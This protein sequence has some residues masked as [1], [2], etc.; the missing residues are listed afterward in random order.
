MSGV[1]IYW[2]NSNIYHEAQRIAEE[3]EGTPGA[4]HL[5]R[6]QFDN[7]LR[8]AHADRPLEKA[9]AAGS[10]PPEMEQL[11]NRMENSGVEVNLFDRGAPDRG[12]QGTPDQWLQ[13]RLLE[14]GWDKQRRSWHCGPTDRR[15]SWLRRRTRV[16]QYVGTYASPRV[17][18]RSPFLDSLV[19]AGNARVGEGQRRLCPAGRLLLRD[20][21]PRAI[22][23]RLRVGASPCPDL[24]GPF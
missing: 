20:H 2:D 11:W 19:Q 9:V 21:L 5:L 3:Q 23:S 14:D 18:D 17:A 10:V 16:S 15:R 6:I 12:E 13:L 24:A 7:L 1:F 4:R 8:L 22:S